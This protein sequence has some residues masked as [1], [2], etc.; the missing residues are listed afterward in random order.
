M[1]DGNQGLAACLRWLLQPHYFLLAM[2]G[3]KHDPGRIYKNNAAS[4]AQN[5]ISQQA[6]VYDHGV[7]LQ[8]YMNWHRN[9]SSSCNRVLGTMHVWQSCLLTMTELTCISR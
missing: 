6:H 2:H 7:M 8:D 4:G 9:R 1:Y 3:D 5:G